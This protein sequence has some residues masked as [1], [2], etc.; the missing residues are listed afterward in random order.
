M[1]EIEENGNNSVVH[2]GL[3]PLAKASTP[4]QGGSSVKVATAGVTLAGDRS[5]KTCLAITFRQLFLV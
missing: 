5:F 2:G 1:H 4:T 3:H